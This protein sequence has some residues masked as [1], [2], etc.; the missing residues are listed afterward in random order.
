MATRKQQDATTLLESDHEKVRKLLSQLEKA[1]Q[2]GRR[3][4]LLAVIAKEVDVHAKI[5]EEIFYPA[6]REAARKKEDAKLFFEAAAEHGVVK[7]V[8]PDLQQT[9]PGGAEFA[10]KAKV[11]KDL[12]EHHAEEEEKEM[13]PRARKLL[14]L[15]ER[16]G[17]GARLATRKSELMVE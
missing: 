9:E 7:M 16:R 11:L 4:Q 14:S 6:F 15:E 17:L 12:I 2:A 13:F 10:G 8:L 1:Q 5:E 3:V